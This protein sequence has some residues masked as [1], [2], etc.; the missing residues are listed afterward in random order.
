M[1][2]IEVAPVLSA[3]SQPEVKVRGRQSASVY[4]LPLSP[5]ELI[6]LSVLDIKFFHGILCHPDIVYRHFEIFTV[7]L[8]L[9]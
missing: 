7:Y 2:F 1:G 5:Y 4:W 6:W 9:N 8:L 3:R